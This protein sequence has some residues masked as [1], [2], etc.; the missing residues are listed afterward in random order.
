[1]DTLLI[2]SKLQSRIGDFSL[3]EIQFFAYLSCLLSL[4]DGHTVTEWNCAFIKSVLGSPYSSDIQ[5]SLELL[6]SNGSILETDRDFYQITEKGTN[7]LSFCKTQKQLNW[8]CSYLETACKSLSV[9]PYGVI[10]EALTREPV[11]FSARNSLI[12]KSL[13]ESSNPATEALHIQFASLKNA[14]EGQY[15]SLIGP[16]IVWIESL[17]SNHLLNYD[18]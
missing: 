4:Y 17:N 11:V 15:K 16:A 6:V 3:S 12:S 14:L 8:R 7:T 13:L 5:S 1:M 10:K 9:L 2:G 18:N